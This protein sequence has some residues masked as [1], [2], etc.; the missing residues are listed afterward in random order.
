MRIK[1]RRRDP[2]VLPGSGEG[3][4]KDSQGTNNQKE[5]EERYK[6]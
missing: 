5:R 4:E 3:Q 2:G 6:Q 1:W